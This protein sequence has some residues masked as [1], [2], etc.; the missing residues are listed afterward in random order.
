MMLH[1]SVGQEELLRTLLTRFIAETKSEIYRTETAE[2]K[3]KLRGQEFQAQMLLEK[4]SEE[5]EE[6]VA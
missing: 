6:K 2:Y 4:L 5:S 1:L 3:D